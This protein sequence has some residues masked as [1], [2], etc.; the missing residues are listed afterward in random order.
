[1]TTGGKKIV[2][3]WLPRPRPC[4]WLALCLLTSQP[5][6]LNQWCQWWWMEFVR[7]HIFSK[8]LLL[9]SLFTKP[10]SAP[11]TNW[12]GLVAG[13]LLRNPIK[14]ARGMAPHV[15]NNEALGTVS[16]GA[17]TEKP[18]PALLQRG[19]SPRPASGTVPARR[20]GRPGSS[21]SQSAPEP[22]TPAPGSTRGA[23]PWGWWAVGI[24][25]LCFGE[26]S[27]CFHLA[28]AQI[29]QCSSLPGT[30]ANFHI[31]ACRG[32]R[33][34]CRAGQ[35]GAAEPRSPALVWREVQHLIRISPAVGNHGSTSSSAS[36]LTWAVHA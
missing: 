24:L 11:C 30:G 14:R 25:S 32:G 13:C 9:L 7:L 15:R 5:D 8:W 19:V 29:S 35:R 1:M 26:P 16:G 34:R 4:V 22:P 18:G 33:S 10:L 3:S 31:S 12:G 27:S 36:L 21:A 23:G 28:E 6:W 17:E 2:V 20:R